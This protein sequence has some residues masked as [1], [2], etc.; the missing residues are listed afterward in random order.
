[1]RKEKTHSRVE[2][3][4]LGLG[5]ST[6]RGHK[7]IT[8][9]GDPDSRTTGDRSQNALFNSLS[10]LPFPYLLKWREQCLIYEV[11]GKNERT[12][13]KGTFSKQEFFILLS[14]D[15]QLKLQS[16]KFDDL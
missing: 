3:A 12:D 5:P 15:I 6:F 16:D 14:L 13:F 7:E 9:T 8:F 1:M 10:K 4:Y 2:M 11:I